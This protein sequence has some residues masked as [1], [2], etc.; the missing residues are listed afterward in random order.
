MAGAG[1]SIGYLLGAIPWADIHFSDEVK[2][3]QSIY[4]LELNITGESSYIK[5]ANDHKQIL[6]TF[7]AIIYVI[8]A[9]ISITSFKEIPINQIKNKIFKNN[10]TSYQKM[11]ES[12]DEEN[13]DHHETNSQATNQFNP[14]SYQ[15]QNVIENANY[16]YEFDNGN[17]TISNADCNNQFKNEENVF[18]EDAEMSNL[19][20]LKYYLTSIIKMPESLRWLCLTHC[21]CWMSL[22]CYSLYFTDF[23][24]EVIF[25]GNPMEDKDDPQSHKTYET[26]VRFGSFCMSFY[27]ISCSLY[28]FFLNVLIKRFSKNSIFILDL[29]FNPNLFFDV[30][31]FYIN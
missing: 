21:F 16:K 27:S 11:N 25:K 23:V 22:L 9:L 10:S 1:G 3:D 28:S 30:Y 18:N 17:D 19:E 4:S 24:G 8:C 5:L 20:T 6:F 2:E 29:I 31:K 7:V 15:N 13:F 14:D 12:D 26:G